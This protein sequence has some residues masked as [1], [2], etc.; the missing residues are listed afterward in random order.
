[1]LLNYVALCPLPEPQV[2]LNEE[3]QEFRWVRLEEA[4]ELDLNGPTQV[5]LEA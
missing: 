2:V 4:W 3:A 5:L 1:L